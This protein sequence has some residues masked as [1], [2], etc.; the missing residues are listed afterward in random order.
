MN[1]LEDVLR[2]NLKAL[3]DELGVN[4]ETVVHKQLIDDYFKAFVCRYT[5]GLSKLVVNSLS[6]TL[7]YFSPKCVHCG[8]HKV[9]NLLIFRVVFTHSFRDQSTDGSFGW[10]AMQPANQQC[11]NFWAAI[12]TQWTPFCGWHFQMHFLGWKFWIPFKISLKF[13]PMV[14]L[15]IFQR[16]FW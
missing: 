11:H 7:S 16:W 12:N 15:T 8:Q 4:L 1:I 2:Q 10:V 14:Q 6:Y 9:F 5:H 3:E 13:F